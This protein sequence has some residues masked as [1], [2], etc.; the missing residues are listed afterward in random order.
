MVFLLQILGKR[1]LYIEGLILIHVK[2]FVLEGYNRY[3]YKGEA[4]LICQS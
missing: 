2:L 4:S 3:K 1:K